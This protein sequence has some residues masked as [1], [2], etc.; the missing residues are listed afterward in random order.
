MLALNYSQ[1]EHNLFGETRYRVPYIY[2]K[3]RLQGT[4]Y[5]KIQFHIQLH[6]VN[7]RMVQCLVKIII[8]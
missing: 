8:I 4:Y 6:M 1:M 7:E 2:N 3:I 5:V